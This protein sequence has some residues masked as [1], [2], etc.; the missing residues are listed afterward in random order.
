M[1]WLKTA[2]LKKKKKFILVNFNNESF[3]G[4]AM[5]QHIYQAALASFLL[6][7]FDNS[8]FIIIKIHC[9]QCFY[10]HVAKCTIIKSKDVSSSFRVL[11]DS[12]C[13][14]CLDGLPITVFNIF[15]FVIQLQI[16]FCILLLACC[17][18]SGNLNWCFMSQFL[19]KWMPIGM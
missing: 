9:N 17:I 2:T 12:Q 6:F 8:N 15:K 4:C 14:V 5:N 11:N 10:N 3:Q 19:L 7:I 18:F 13:L 16:V 1:P